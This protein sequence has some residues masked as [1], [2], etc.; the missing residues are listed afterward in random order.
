MLSIVLG[1][2]TFLMST[3][4]AAPAADTTRCTEAD[5]PA[6]V[7]CDSTEPGLEVATGV[8]RES[9]AGAQL[10]G[11][12]EARGGT[13]A[14]DEIRV[15]DPQLIPDLQPGDAVIVYRRPG[16]TEVFPAR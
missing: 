4:R 15:N 6:V 13:V 1:S 12:E 16:S 11:V 10:I 2:L 5:S 14:L 8:V 3:A 9:D 7:L